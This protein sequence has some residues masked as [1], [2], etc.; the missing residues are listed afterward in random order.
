[1]ILK[2]H[3]KLTMTEEDKGAFDH[4]TKC[5]ISD[6]ILGNYKI[7]DVCHI[8][9]KY[10]GTAHNACYLTLRIYPY[11]TKIPVVFHIFRGHDG[12]LIMAE[13]VKTKSDKWNKINC[14]QNNMEKITTFIIGQL[15]F[16]DSLQFLN[17]SQYNLVK[18]LQTEELKITASVAVPRG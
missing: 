12:H 10:R 15:Q 8:S 9:G 16:I 6:E 17:T 11:K 5:H 7:C 14:I 1:M 13:M 3:A 2:N 18:G 4:A